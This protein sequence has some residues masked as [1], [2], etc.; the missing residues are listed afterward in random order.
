MLKADPTAALV[1]YWLGDRRWRFREGR[2]MEAI[3]RGEADGGERTVGEPLPVLL[4]WTVLL[5]PRIE[6]P[7]AKETS[8]LR[9]G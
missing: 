6:T 5:L 8:H 7:F 2:L 3:L 4:L 1:P 9:D